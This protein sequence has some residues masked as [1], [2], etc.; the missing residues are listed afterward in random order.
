MGM[1]TWQ[2][3]LAGQ[4]VNPGRKAKSLGLEDGEPRTQSI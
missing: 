2:V 4:V 1:V 3:G